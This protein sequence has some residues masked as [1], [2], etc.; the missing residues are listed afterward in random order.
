MLHIDLPTRSEIE[1]L[2]AV[3]AEPCVSI[4]LATTPLTQDAQADRIALKNL[5]REAA[6]QLEAAGTPK[7][8]IWPIEE[9]VDYLIA[10]DEFW[11]YQANSLAIFATPERTRT[12]RLPNRL[13]SMVQVSDRFH[14]NPILRAVTFRQDA[15]VLAISKGAL[16]LVEVSADLPPHEVSV[17][18]LPRDM[19]DA[20]GRRSHT[21]RTGAMTSGESSSEHALLTR[22]ARAADHALRPILS[23][24]ERP[25]IVAASEPLASIYPAVCSY[26]HVASRVIDGNPDRVPDHALAAAAREVLDGIH[27]DAL[28]EVASLFSARDG[29]GRATGDIAVAARAATWGA[30]DTLVVDMDAVRPGTVGDEDGAVTF[31]DGPSASSYGVVD[32]IAGRALRSGARVLAARRG[33]IPGGGELAA[34]LR[35]T[36]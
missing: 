5:M 35:Y 17:P 1:A 3:R 6:A 11:A 8:S 2:S 21:E 20:I 15:Y 25:L 24:H 28:A 27:A 7:R 13:E 9:A 33:D 4:Y 36:I 12:F 34:I 30:V 26:P 31:A 19:N 14:I 10:D 29:Q 23:G 22:Y 18:G 16:R 32:E